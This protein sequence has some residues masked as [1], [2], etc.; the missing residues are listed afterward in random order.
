MGNHH[1]AFSS[2][3]CS[4]VSSDVSDVS[5]RSGLERRLFVTNWR[6]YWRERGFK[7]KIALGAAEPQ[8]A[9]AGNRTQIRA[10]ESRGGLAEQSMHSTFYSTA[11][12]PMSSPTETH[13]RPDWIL[14]CWTQPWSVRRHVRRPETLP[15]LS[16]L[17]LLLPP[18]RPLPRT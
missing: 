3:D 2:I 9:S 17:S 16:S 12:W 14:L 6:Y 11:R 8:R 5:W 4:V 18:P 10:A 1:L 13:H 7:P 15:P